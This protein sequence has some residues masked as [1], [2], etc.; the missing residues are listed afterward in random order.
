MSRIDPE[1]LYLI[2][3]KVAA[4][5]TFYGYDPAQLATTGQK[6]G[7][8]S[9][10]Q[11]AEVYERVTGNRVGATLKWSTHFTQLDGLLAGCGLPSLSVVA[12]PGATDDRVI[13]AMATKWP[14]FSGL[15]KLYRSN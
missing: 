5:Q 14:P 7:T 8:I 11:L 6:P 12:D 9:T 2:L 4:K 1:V 13:K 3:T 15:K 10:R